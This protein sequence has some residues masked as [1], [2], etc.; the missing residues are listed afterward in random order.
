MRS[1]T[2]PCGCSLTRSASEQ[3]CAALLRIKARAKYTCA[4]RQTLRAYRA[5]D[6]RDKFESLAR[7][8]L[9]TDRVFD[10]DFL[11]AFLQQRAGPEDLHRNVD[12]SR[13]VPIDPRLRGTPYTLR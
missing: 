8:H 12:S 9:P 13:C 2:P 3:S 10:V 4:S 7:R 6:L 11:A 5:R 1:Y